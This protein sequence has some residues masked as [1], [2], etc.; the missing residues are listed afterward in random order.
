MP[1]NSMT[2]QYSGTSLDAQ[3]HYAQAIKDMFR[4]LLQLHAFKREY[5][6]VHGGELATA[7]Y[8]EKK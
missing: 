5:V 2:P 1:Y 8:G 4:G 7:S 6:I 3:K